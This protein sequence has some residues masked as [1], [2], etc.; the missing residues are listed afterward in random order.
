MDR[1]SLPSSSCRHKPRQA[2][3]LRPMSEPV[4]KSTYRRLKL[5]VVQQGVA[6][7]VA[8]I[9]ALQSQWGNKAM[10]PAHSVSPGPDARPTRPPRHARQHSVVSAVSGSSAGESSE[11][12]MWTPTEPTPLQS[13]AVPPPADSGAAV[14]AGR[15]SPGPKRRAQSNAPGARKRFPA[16]ACMLIWVRGLAEALTASA[17][18]QLQSK[19]LQHLM[20]Y[21]FP[22]QP[23]PV[24]QWMLQLW[25]CV[26]GAASNTQVPY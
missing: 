18:P 17:Y 10:Q 7:A 26:A 22:N 6:S 8:E 13:D 4:G 12:G 3:S 9:N 16:A 11:A 25:Q 24:R 2:S 23:L 15:S 19:M 1:S 20:N 14:P 21:Y 5:Q